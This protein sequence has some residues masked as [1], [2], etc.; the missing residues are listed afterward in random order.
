[1]NIVRKTALKLPIIKKFGKNGHYVARKMSSITKK[2]K[3]L[4]NITNNTLLSSTSIQKRD[5][6]GIPP[7]NFDNDDIEEAL[8]L[9]EAVSNELSDELANAESIDSQLEDVMGA[10]LNDFELM[11]NEKSTN[12]ELR[13][14]YDSNSGAEEIIIKFNVQDENREDVMM[15]DMGFDDESMQQFEQQMNAMQSGQQGSDEVAEDFSTGGEDDTYGIDFQVIIKKNADTFVLDCVAGPTIIVK[16]ACFNPVKE[17]NDLY[18]GPSF[19][20]MDES[21][22]RSFVGYLEE[23]GIGDDMN[24]FVLAYSQ[25]KENK[26]Y[27]N[28]L[29]KLREFSD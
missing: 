4:L 21:F 26:E 1:M 27:V 9:S 25:K 10:V 2:Q 8:P 11:E 18:R 23:R 29:L 7:M 16:R 24:F 15:N 3:Q 14:I 13:R 6:S 17:N 28:W 12:E 22:I 20:A 19:E 5:L